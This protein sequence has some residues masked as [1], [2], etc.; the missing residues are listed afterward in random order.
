MATVVFSALGAG[1]GSSIGGSLLGLS[2]TAVGR[3]AGAMIGRSI[4]N[5]LSQG[6]SDVVES[7]KLDRIRLSSVGEGVPIPHVFG[8]TRIGG[9]VIWASNFHERIEKSGGVSAAKGT[10][11]EPT[12]KTYK[13][14]VSLA[15]ALC[16][17]VIADVARVW[18]DGVEVA[19]SDLNMRIYHGTSVQEPD[20]KMEA[21]EGKGQV[22]AYRGLAYVVFEDLQL[23]QFGNRVPQFSFEVCRPAQSNP[24]LAKET[25]EIVKAVAMI[26]GSGEYALATDPITYDFGEG[27]YE[28]ANKHSPSKQSDF[29]T[30]LDMLEA[31]LP[32]CKATSLVVSWFGDDLRCAHCTLSPKVEHKLA[33]SE[34]MPW[35]VSGLSRQSAQEVVKVD[36]RPVYGGTPT[37]Q[38]VVQSINALKERGQDVMFYPFI[39]MDQTVGNNLPNPYDVEG[40][41]AEL[42]WRGRITLNKAPTVEGTSDR[43]AVAETEV[44]AFFGTTQHTD[45]KIENGDIIYSGPNEW[46]YRRFVLHYAWLCK[47]AGDV[48]AF[49]I[50]SELRG[51][52]QIRGEN[53]TFPAVDQLV[54]LANDVRAILGSKT[55]IGYAAD[56]SEYF[57]YHPQDGSGDVYFHL[58][59][60]WAD[61]AI[62][63][64]GIDNYMPLSDWRDERDHHDAHAGSI[65]S[66]EYLKSNIEGGEGYDWFY[67]SDTDR[68]AQKR[69]PISDDHYQE[70]WVWRYKDI[71]NWWLNEHFE[72]RAGSRSEVPTAW[73]AQS[74]P[75]WF[76]EIGCAALDKATNQPNKFLDPKSSESEKPYFSDGKR[77]ELIQLS[78][79]QAMTSYWEKSENNPISHVYNGSMLDTSRTFVWAWDARPYPWFPNASSIWS[80]GPNYERGHWLNGRSSC[81]SLAAV[82][83]EIC[84]LAGIKKY[85]VAGLYGYV[86]GYDVRSVHDGRSLLQP[87]ALKY[88]ISIVEK[89]GVLTFTSQGTETVWD[90]DPDYLVETSEL[91]AGL[92]YSR[93]NDASLIGRVQ[94]SFPQADGDYDT[95]S[96][97]TILQGYET[98]SVANNEMPLVMTRAEGYE[99]IQQW[100]IDAQLAKEK[101]KFA[102]PFSMRS[103]AMGDVL[104]F[105]GQAGIYYRVDRVERENIQIIEA[106]RVDPF[107][108][109]AANYMASDVSL[110]QPIIA[111][112][113][114][115]VFLDLPNISDNHSSFA[116]FIAASARPWV[117]PVAVYED[118]GQ[119]DWELKQIVGRP[120]VVGKLLSQLDHGPIDR[121]DNGRIV[122]VQIREGTLESVTLPSLLKGSN[123]AAI[124]TGGSL[125]WEVIQFQ[126]AELIAPKTYR[127]SGLLRGRFGSDVEMAQQWAAG[128][129]FVML[130]G[131]EQLAMTAAELE[132]DISL[133]FGPTSV[134]MDEDTYRTA[135]LNPRSIG[136][137]PLR[138]C[139]LKVKRDGNTIDCTWIRRGRVAAD[140]W[141]DTDIPYAEDA[142]EFKVTLLQNEQV[143]DEQ[144]KTTTSCRFA[145]D[146]L[147]NPTSGFS[148]EVAQYS[149]SYG[150]GPS[151]CVTIN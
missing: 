20:P 23:Y 5:R 9:Q 141:W 26:P 10:P 15:V 32:K 6:G 35:S 30:S 138:P 139:H 122:D 4:D 97:E 117:A 109:C 65:Y 45:F 151:T 64:V 19:K 103:V 81:Q 104:Q 72:R 28:S 116:P 150:Y 56:W 129:R 38:S 144:I 136:L 48:S 84:E 52:T 87:L 148:I 31:E 75:I 137:R 147:P 46:S 41:Q 68:L 77:D 110:A 63:F 100:L 2:M 83:A 11:P 60:L 53:D 47:L 119:Q 112:P 51:L 25:A 54:V 79:L 134:S 93:S 58:D 24:N 43:S 86:R 57:G 146:L 123:L 14:S 115:L 33:E 130:D 12:L 74:K 132:G 66:L 39:L 59:K 1:L 91:D 128:A 98:T 142:Q 133:H 37:D 44:N 18:A 76:T 85:D 114:D 62:D 121:I 27:L 40:T 149:P 55:K 21:I 95:V 3:F 17:G 80:D 71:R 36:S 126:R 135:T 113:V 131:A 89:A 120:T 124:G 82:V 99:T 105:T 73:V 7:G 118:K 101:V 88:G 125:G 92:V 49:C 106:T 42:P 108:K 13:Y 29:V 102:L 22:P 50:G 145:S 78:Y 67:A 8:R 90:I 140:R 96:E 34:K 16:P 143:V 61:D 94:L 111:Q 127:L 70:P 107:S 69:T